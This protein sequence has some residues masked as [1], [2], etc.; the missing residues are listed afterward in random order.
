MSTKKAAKKP[1][2]KA[3]NKAPKKAASKHARKAAKKVAAK[4]EESYDSDGAIRQFNCNELI[5]SDLAAA[6]SFYTQLF[7]WKAKPFGH[8]MDYTILEN[9]GKSA[10][11]LMKTPDGGPSP[12]WLA[13]VSVADIHAAV[14][15]L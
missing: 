5:T 8:G 7:G 6:T 14:A 11:G 13:Y 9:G 3:Q 10:G 1:A 4:A 2:K 15:K 12:M